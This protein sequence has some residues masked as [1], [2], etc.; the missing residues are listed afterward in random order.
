VLDYQRV[1]SFGHAWNI[2]WKKS[3]TSW[4]VVYPIIYRAQGGAGFLSV[5][6]HVIQ[7]H[8]GT[9]QHPMRLGR[10]TDTLLQSHDGSLGSQLFFGWKGGFF[11]F[12]G[13]EN[14]QTR[15]GWWFQP[16]P[17]EKYESQSGWWNSQYMEKWK[18]FQTFN[19]N[20]L[21]KIQQKWW[22][23]FPSWIASVN[24]FEASPVN[25]QA[26]KSPPGNLSFTTSIHTLGHGTVKRWVTVTGKKVSMVYFM[27]IYLDLQPTS[28]YNW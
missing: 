12:N 17:Y 21:L 25:F 22:V 4:Q 5:V 20:D 11:A 2:Q 6:F 28:Y 16:Y 18:M 23:S 15:S 13:G 9:P 26:I 8:W 7:G 10:C 24:L 14:Q 1:R 27:G 3:Y 19:K